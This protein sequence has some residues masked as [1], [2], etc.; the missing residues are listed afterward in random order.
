M[1]VEDYDIS[2]DKGEFV[3]GI[4]HVVRGQVEVIRYRAR[5]ST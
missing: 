1:N 2:Q 4:E 5:T 3:K